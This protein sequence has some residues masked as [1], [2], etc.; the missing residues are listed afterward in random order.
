VA[1]AIGLMTF[2]EFELLPEHPGKQ[3]LVKGELIELPPPKKKHNLVADAFFLALVEAM[4]KMRAEG[5]HPPMS[6]PHREMGYRVTRNPDSWLIPDV[7]ISYPDHAGDEYFEGSPLLAIEVVSP[8]NTAEEIEAKI[9][10][11]LASGSQE[12]WV[13]YPKTVSL[14]VYR[15]NS[16]VL[17][18]GT[19]QST[20]VSTFSIDLVKLLS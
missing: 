12:V 14:W 5:A 8:S 11:Y 2:E 6:I 9:E 20:L 4:T 7:S 3:E 1:T 15:Q 18:T 19:F 10:I 17:I 13:L 16:A